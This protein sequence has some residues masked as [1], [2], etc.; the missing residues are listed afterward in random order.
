MALLRCDECGSNET[1]SFGSWDT[2]IKI[3]CTKCSTM[4]KKSTTPVS[5]EKESSTEINISDIGVGRMTT[6]ATVILTTLM[7]EDD[8]VSRA[9]VLESVMK[10]LSIEPGDFEK[11]RRN[12][13]KHIALEYDNDETYSWEC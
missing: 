8:V 1:N 13:K 10:H 4:K 9:R 11:M 3:S 7:I 12:E 6:T 5:R 2:P